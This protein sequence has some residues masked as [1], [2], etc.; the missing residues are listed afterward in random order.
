M[1]EMRRL[2]G[3]FLA[4][5]VVSCDALPAARSP[6]PT[7]PIGEVW[8][9][10]AALLAPGA[11]IS[12]HRLEEALEG[13]DLRAVLGTNADIVIAQVRKTRAA[14]D[15]AWKPASAA[16]GQRLT[17][18]VS[19]VGLFSVPIFA[20]TLASSLDVQ[21]QSPNNVTRPS[22]PFTSNENSNGVFT[23]TTVNI[24][25]TYGASGSKVGLTMR[26]S[27]TTA[28]IENGLT[29]YTLS[30]DRTMTGSIDVCPDTSG[31]VTATLN[32]EQT[33]K[34][35]AK[36][37]ITSRQA[38]SSNAFVG[39]VGDDAYLRS[40]RQTFHE[41]STWDVSSGSGSYGIDMTATYDA[42][43]SGGFFGGSM[44]S[45]PGSV[46]SA[47]GDA[48][49]AGTIGKYAGFSLVVDAL[50]LDEAYK[51]AQRLWRNG[52]CVMVRA[53]DY[54]S[55]TPINTGSQEK[56][57]HDE[58]V[59]VAS[60]TKFSVNLKHRFAGGGLSQPVTAALASGGKK[61][62]P[63]RLDSVPSSL[64]YTAPDE[65]DKKATVAL[66][67]TSKRGIGTLYLDFHTGGEGL[68]LT[69]S[70][71]LKLRRSFI[72]TL[73]EVTDI[74]QIGPVE[75]KKT[76]AD[77]WEGTGTWTAQTSSFTSVPGRTERCTGAQSGR[78]TML[79]TYDTSG[80]NKVWVIEPLDGSTTGAATTS[81]PG[82]INL[83]AEAADQFLGTFKTFIIPEQGGV[84]ALHGAQGNPA[85]GEISGDG[86]LNAKTKSGSG[87]SR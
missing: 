50:S 45:G 73:T 28:S 36:G 70:G 66:K 1:S 27:Y 43:Q 54:G 46:S 44:Q 17:S 6:A 74:V 32:V 12:D 20:Q 62:E 23:T 47:T 24:A 26:W 35:N 31:S 11:D 41:Q 64:T 82:E 13:A 39:T 56:S 37:K 38:S 15:A 8:Q 2:S 83:A 84:Q 29:V 21:T 78:I 81:C 76:F 80:P 55:E 68:T 52:R 18:V 85:I 69:I 9:T 42:S 67:S 3:L 60:E 77:M 72:G 22:N 87:G 48:T 7:G 33:V 16:G 4:L 34:S 71:T 5:A 25:E 79:A 30:D 57:Q 58:Q 75:F 51:A 63:G 86:T 49:Q 65:Q 61:L 59:D 10:A 19:N 14:V 53:P 40:V